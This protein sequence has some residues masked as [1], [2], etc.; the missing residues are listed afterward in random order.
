MKKNFLAFILL[1]ALF[2]ASCTENDNP[3]PNTQEKGCTDPLA[4]NYK[5][6]AKEEDCSCEYKM[7]SNVSKTVPASL[8]TKVL[9][10]QM[11]GT[12]CGWCV[13]GTLRMNELIAA[14]PNRVIGAVVH[15]GDAMQ[16]TSIYN[17]LNSTYK[18]NGFPSGMVNR[19]P[20]SSSG[21][22]VM[23]R[24]EW[25]TN[26]TTALG[27][28]VNMGLGIDASISGPLLTVML[29]VANKTET[30]E[31]YSVIAYLLEDGLVYS[32]NNYYSNLAGATTHPF[33]SQPSVIANYTHNKVVRKMLTD[34][35]G[36]SLPNA[37]KSANK[38]YR[39]LFVTDLENFNK[40]KLR[41]VAFVVKQGTRPEV[42]NVQE[43]VLNTDTGSKNFD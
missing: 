43:L 38:I 24:G 14:N 25:S 39:R 8:T 41:I 13:D 20:S 22:I 31:N 4:E 36:V 5:S 26:A 29:H 10:E 15:Q 16:N 42:V 32:Q 27:Q 37:A 3:Q 1:N 21:D 28:S 9:L 35:V 6:T 18:V 30:T 12:W 23:G 19:K 11:T 17:Y 7:N 33:Y 34:N 40:T 2:V